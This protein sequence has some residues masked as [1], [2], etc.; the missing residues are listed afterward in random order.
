M[1]YLN[2]SNTGV[3]KNLLNQYIFQKLKESTFKKQKG[4]NK[5]FKL[6]TSALFQNVQNGR[7][8]FLSEV[9]TF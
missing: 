4:L 7:S 6:M 3:H 9:M 1:E 2:K 8:I 5:Y